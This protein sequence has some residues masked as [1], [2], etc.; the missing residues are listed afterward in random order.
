MKAILPFALAALAFAAPAA[1]QTANDDLIC[2]AW[3]ANSG[4]QASSEE[5]KDV[6]AMAMFYYIGRWEAA[7][8][9]PLEAGLTPKFVADN[10]KAISTAGPTCQGR[11]LELAKRMQVAGQALIN[12]SKR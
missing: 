7:T 12:S 6:M 10:Y 5:E 1:A 9:R 4:D 2:V 3:A 11:M 8:G